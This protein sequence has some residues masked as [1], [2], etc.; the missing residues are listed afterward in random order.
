MGKLRDSAKQKKELPPAMYFES[1]RRVHYKNNIMRTKAHQIYHDPEALR[2]DIF[3]YKKKLEDKLRENNSLKKKYD[4]L[5]VENTHYENFIQ[6][7]EY[8]WNTNEN[9]QVKTIIWT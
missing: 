9:N 1:W 2:E 3:E 5:E 6:N 7:N 8:F 4:K